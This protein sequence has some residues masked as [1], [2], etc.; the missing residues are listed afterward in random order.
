MERRFRLVLACPDRV[1]IVAMVSNFISS[2][3]G[4]ISDANQHTDGTTGWFFMRVEISAKTLPFSLEEL[5]EAFSP[6]AQS[7]NMDWDMTD[8][9]QPKKVILMASRQSHCLAD[10][11]YRYHEG[12]LDCEIPCVISN[13]DDLRSMVEW[14]NIPYHHVPVDK[15]N[16]EPHFAEVSRLIREHKADTVVLARYMQILPTDICAEYAHRIINIHHSFLP[17]FAGAKPYHQAHERG[18]KLIGA[19]CHYVTE[20]LDAGPI[21]DQDV[22]RIS[23]RD[24]PDEMVRLGRDVEK[25]VLSRGLR[26]H[27]E[28]RILVQGNKTVVFN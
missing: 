25:T 17:S 13:H 7:F 16:K 1:G 23:H 15:E 11:L 5:K 28:D 12:E 4:S 2:H 22:I 10:L 9:A 6:I 8:S 14:H 18:V 20:E 26:W 27:L 24:M 19:T 21:I 3:G